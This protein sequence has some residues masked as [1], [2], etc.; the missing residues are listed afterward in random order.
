MMVGFAEGSN[1]LQLSAVWKILHI[2]TSLIFK[3]R[4]VVVLPQ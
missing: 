4:S 3:W 1:G 2:V